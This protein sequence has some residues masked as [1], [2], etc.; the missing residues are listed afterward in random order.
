M[1]TSGGWGFSAAEIPD[2]GGRERGGVPGEEPRTN[3]KRVDNNDARY[4]AD[5]LV[6]RVA[7]TLQ[8]STL[9]LLADG[10]G[11]GGK[12]PGGA[13]AYARLAV[14]F[15]S[16]LSCERRSERTPSPSEPGESSRVHAPRPAVS[17]FGSVGVCR[18]SRPLTF[19][20]SSASL[21]LTLPVSPSCLC[22][23]ESTPHFGGHSLA[24][25]AAPAT[26]CLSP[27]APSVFASLPPTGTLFAPPLS[28][29]V[30]PL[31][32]LPRPLPLSL[33]LAFSVSFSMVSR[34]GPLSCVTLYLCYS[35]TPLYRFGWHFLAHS[36]S[37]ASTLDFHFLFSCLLCL[38]QTRVTE[39]GR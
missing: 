13:D 7:R 37:T 5:R 38:C 6:L 20:P 17:V 29:L 9:R 10:V 33:L 16:A 3:G 26:L 32:S 25:P 27:R 30:R 34:P 11:Q 35:H 1:S 12:G 28:S 31:T 19:P 8:C 22:D 18:S 4:A 21:S 23:G 24:A 39:G 14:F 36:S 15:F 2:E